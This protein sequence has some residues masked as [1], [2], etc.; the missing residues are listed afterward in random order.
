MKY[1]AEYGLGDIVYL[2]TDKEQDPYIIIQVSFRPDGVIYQLA[3]GSNSSWCY[4]I[5]MSRQRDL[6]FSIIGQ[7]KPN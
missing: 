1:E 6:V 7:N 2:I 3:K 4:G 5:E